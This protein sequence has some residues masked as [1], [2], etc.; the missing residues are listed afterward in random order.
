MGR[1]PQDEIERLKREISIAELVRAS[2]V[3][4]ERQGANLVGR[5][6]G[7]DDKTPSLVVTPD[8]GLWHCMG[9]CQKG[10]TVVDWTMWRS[11]VSFRHAIALLRGGA[12]A[13]AENA[14]P[15]RATTRKLS[16]LAEGGASDAELLGRVVRLY[17]DT[18]NQHPEGKGYLSS[19]GLEHPELIDHF[20]LGYA[21]RTLG[22]RLPHS[23]T[24]LGARLRGRL[25]E[26]GVYRQSGHEFLSG[27]LVVPLFD[28][29]GG[30]ASLYGRKVQEHHREGTPKH[31]YLPGGHRGVFNRA[32]LAESEEAILCEALFDAM[33]FWCAGYRN[34]TSAYGVEGFTDEIAQALAAAKVRRVKIAFDRDEAGDRGAERVARKL[35]ALGMETFRVVFPRG[36]DAN[37]Y[38]RKVAPADKSLGLVLRQAQWMGKGQAPARSIVETKACA[39]PEREET[40][41]AIPLLVASSEGGAELDAKP[42]PPVTSPA[43]SSPTPAPTLTAPTTPTGV[44]LEKDGN[45]LYLTFSQSKRRWRVRPGSKVAVPGEL[46]V[47]VLVSHEGHSSA[48]FV[49][50]VDLYSARQRAVFTKQASEELH[51]A[52]EELR[53]ELGAIVLEV[54]RALDVRVEQAKAPD[55]TAMTAE[56]REEALALLRDPKLLDRVLED[57][58]RAGVVGEETNK[59]VSYLAAT[60]RKLEEP[61]AVVIQ[62]SSAAGKSSLM[63]AVLALMPDEERV[64]YSAMTGQSLFYMNGQSLKNKILAIVEEEGAERASYAL[65]LLQSEGELTI[66]STGKDPATGRHVTQTYRVEGPVMIMLTTTAVDVDEEL[67]N[68]CLILSVDE[69]REQTKAIHERQRRGQTLEG[70]LAREE[71]QHVRRVHKNAQRLLKPMMVVNPFAMELS[72]ADHATRTRR[73]HMKYLTLINAV[74]LLHQHQ[75]PL[76]S[77]MH[78]GRRIEYIEA[79]RQ[80]IA[81]ATRLAQGVLGRGLDELPPQTRRLLELLVVMVRERVQAEGASRAEVR[82]TRRQVREWTQ[83]GQTQ[84]K[85]HLDR[86][87][88]HEYLLAHRFGRSARLHQYELLVPDEGPASAYDPTSSGAKGT[89]SGGH[90]AFIGGTPDEE[91]RS[92]TAPNVASSLN[93]AKTTVPAQA[94]RAAS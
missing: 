71:R 48:F 59:L 27:S 56:E 94:P 54:E 14:A 29:E 3:E 34:V 64:Q 52:E 73:D 7:H 12:G 33:T 80:D 93:G 23:Q 42:E 6:P 18:L 58:A 15:K 37:E 49:D 63:E 31:L 41:E 11:G 21:N 57:L 16:P 88:E 68:R 69:G 26:L 82:F 9:A 78:R 32:A 91:K 89:S 79:T 84:L 50:T 36:M 47:N 43:P 75:R 8:K 67:L 35:E 1:I 28:E 17:H 70:R 44:K 53:R 62:S 81:T 46:K 13:S 38:A 4:L 2:G 77:A 51:V 72:F 10:G 60:S 90:R 74:A 39:E 20:Q 87:E 86:L 61:L 66:A 24:Q 65:K 30:I 83:W 45:D 5:C 22:Y 19:R 55:P 40:P 92:K 76:K 25:V 85:L